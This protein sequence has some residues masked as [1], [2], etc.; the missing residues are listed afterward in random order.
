MPHSKR[1]KPRPQVFDLMNYFILDWE[2]LKGRAI[3]VLEAITAEGKSGGP[4][5]M[6]CSF[7]R[8]IQSRLYVSNNGKLLIRLSRK[9]LKSFLVNSAEAIT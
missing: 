3:D 4:G 6:V 1:L 7:G 9:N 5:R 8:L 2:L